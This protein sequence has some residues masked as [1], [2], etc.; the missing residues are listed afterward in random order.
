[1]NTVDLLNLNSLLKMF[2]E[3]FVTLTVSLKFSDPTGSHSGDKTETHVDNIAPDTEDTPLVREKIRDII[4]LSA[5]IFLM[6]SS[7]ALAV[8]FLRVFHRVHSK[9]NKTVFN[10]KSAV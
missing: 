6:I 3:H 1:M 2:Y 4:G 7:V 10:G 5:G 8:C 9:K